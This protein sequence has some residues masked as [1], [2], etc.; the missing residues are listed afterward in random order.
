M[1]HLLFGSLTQSFIGHPF[2]VF[3]LQVQPSAILSKTSRHDYQTGT[4]D[5]WILPSPAGTGVDYL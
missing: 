4:P 1:L 5:S 3:C 2:L